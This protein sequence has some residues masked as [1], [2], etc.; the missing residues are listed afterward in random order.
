MYTMAE[1]C[2]QFGISR[3]ALRNWV[4]EFS[5]YLSEAVNVEARRQRRLSDEDMQVLALVGEWKSRGKLF[6][7]IHEALATRN[8]YGC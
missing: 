6:A 7:E 4:I 5:P 2:K 8:I 1:A 3:E